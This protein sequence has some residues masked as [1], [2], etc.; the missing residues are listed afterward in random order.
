MKKMNEQRMD[1]LLSQYVDGRLS[2]N[3]LKE[4][5]AMLSENA[6]ARKRLKDLLVLKDLL[7]SKQKLTQDIG[8]W[9][10]FSAELERQ[11]QIK[12]NAPSFTRK[13][14]P[15]LSAAAAVVFIVAGSIVYQNM[16]KQTDQSTGGIQVSEDV[17]NS[18]RMQGQLMPF[19]SKI[20]KDRA[21]QFSL[22]GTLP[23]DEKSKTELRMD[24]QSEK[25]YRI[26]VA[27]D[28]KNKA[29][30]IT[31]DRFIAEVKPS[32]RQ[33]RLIDSL[34][35]L[36]SR[37][38]ESSVLIGENNVMAIAPDLPNINKMMVTNI[39]ACLEPYQRVQ[40]ERLL[41]ANDAPYTVT[42]KNGTTEA[43]NR[44]FQRIPQLPRDNR[45]VIIT[46][47]TMIYSQIQIDFD[48]M[49]KQ[50]SEDVRALEQRREAMLKRILS[51]DF[52][53]LRNS[54][55]YPQHGNAFGHEEFFN[56]EI[57]VPADEIDQQQMHLMVQPRV[58]KR[59]MHTVSPG[60]AIEIRDSK[61][62]ALQNISR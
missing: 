14:M 45:F 21:L 24:K 29:N 44:V 16:I 48:S 40:F 41:E 7:A 61:D 32:S 33:K 15:A 59:I 12:Q 38:I 9:T 42:V 49:R 55:P 4:V 8:F 56:V 20:D 26:E 28:S 58:R 18:G 52:N 3:E 62:S 51:K 6:S 39:A 1:E 30:T 19:F 60:S 23:I 13:F 43:E 10:R 31:F 46:P 53:R 27:K 2:E 47:D 22:L 50:M 17:P 37:R 35:E 54:S 11:N 5:E 25:G 57:I 34:L 36:T